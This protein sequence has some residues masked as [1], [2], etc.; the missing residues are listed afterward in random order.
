[1]YYTSTPALSATGYKD[2]R[3]AVL[4]VAIAGSEVAAPLRKGA[5]RRR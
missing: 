4:A 1:M 3:I 5:L 2:S